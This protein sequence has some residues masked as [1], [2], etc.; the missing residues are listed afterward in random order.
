MYT[1]CST[2]QFVV[3]LYKDQRKNDAKKCNRLYRI[4]NYCNVTTDRALLFCSW[5]FLEPF[6]SYST[7]GGQNN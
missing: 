4:Y 2:M 5:H 7:V 1:Q 3:F 6:G